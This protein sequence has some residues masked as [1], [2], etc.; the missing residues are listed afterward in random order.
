MAETTTI[1]NGAPAQHY[2]GT[3]GPTKGRALT[4]WQDFEGELRNREREIASMLP[5]HISRERFLNSAIAAV[6]QNPDLLRA[7]PRSLFAAVTKSAQDGILPDG[8]EGVIT[9]YNVKDEGMVAQWNPMTYGLRKRARELD[10]IIIDAQVVCEGDKFLWH[11]GDEPKI[12]HI[13]AQLGQPRG[14]KIGAYA[15]FKRESGVILHREVMDYTMIETVRAQSKAANSLMWTKFSEEGYRKTVIR[16]GIKSVP[17]SENL[18]QI[19]RRDDD[20]FDF[21]AKP[22]NGVLTPPRPT[23]GTSEFERKEPNPPTAPAKPNGGHE[24]VVAPGTAPTDKARYA[25][26]EEGS[27]PVTDAAW[28][29]A[30]FGPGGTPLPAQTTEPVEETALDRGIRLLAL[31]KSITDVGDLRETIAQELPEAEQMPWSLKCG[32]RSREITDAISKAGKAKGK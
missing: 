30:G 31:C 23:R 32:A 18:E 8:R 16:R 9:I 7:T 11:Q 4:A 21:D 29:A 6:K 27:A 17:V 25:P 13:P 19:V 24:P 22:E 2:E 15:I 14:K 10:E 3:P 28:A 12:E 20:L 1:E 5:T 26:P